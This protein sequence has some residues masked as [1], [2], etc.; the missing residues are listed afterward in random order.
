MSKYI[1]KSDLPAFLGHLQ[2]FGQV[3]APLAAEGVTVFS[4]W[5]AG[6]EVELDEVR[7]ANS[8]K[9]FLFPQRE[10][11]FRVEGEE[12]TEVLPSERRVVFG[13]RPCDLASRRPFERVFGSGPGSDPYLEARREQTILIGLACEHP[14]PSC[15]CTAF[16]LSPAA[17][18]G[19]VMLYPDAGR[20][21]VEAVTTRGAELLA[22][23]PL[24]E[25]GSESEVA[26]RK[27]EL[28]RVP[29]P[30]GE[31]LL[32]PDLPKL[33]AG[34]FQHPLWEALAT[35]CL[36][37]GIC[38]YSCPTCHCFLLTDETGPAGSVQRV[39]GWDSCQFP[40]FTL[41]AGG[42]NPRSARS[43]RV[44]QRFL[45]KLAFFPERQGQYLCVG[46][47]R[48]LDY[49]PVGLDIVGVIAAVKEASAHGG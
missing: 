10:V 42:A 46:C 36:S 45:H 23:A 48:C 16:G 9:D 1:L 27:E 6:V 32:P 39:R 30:L 31:N 12:I 20:F 40:S 44:R 2:Q 3:M 43:A 33:A 5:A 47:G 22:S 7:T 11:L 34:L 13:V 29:V 15:F 21:W 18:G 8:V 19:D 28:A 24:S 14:K 26:R 17:A 25:G 49:C 4:P 41:A 37:C 38:T 35:R